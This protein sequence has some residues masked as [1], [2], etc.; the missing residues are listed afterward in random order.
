MFMH[1]Y[2]G[3]EQS[4]Q[5]AHKYTVWRKEECQE[6]YIRANAHARRKATLL[7]L[8]AP[9]SRGLLGTRGRVLRARS[10][11]NLSTLERENTAPLLLEGNL[12]KVL[13]LV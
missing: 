8:L 3:D 1:I 4:G 5:K 2:N 9:L 11:R 7:W 10:T 13:L 6:A 12:I